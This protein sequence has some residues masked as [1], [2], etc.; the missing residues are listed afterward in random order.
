MG[1]YGCTGSLGIQYHG[2]DKDSMLLFEAY[3]YLE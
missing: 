1:I 2:G 3:A